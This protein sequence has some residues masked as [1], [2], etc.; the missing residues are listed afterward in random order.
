MDT[1]ATSARNTT[2]AFN[3]HV[4]WRK[5]KGILDKYFNIPKVFKIKH[6]QWFCMRK[7]NRG[8]LYALKLHDS[9]P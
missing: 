2:A 9:S 8:V 3:A 4:S 1:F 6:Y 5:W 7:K